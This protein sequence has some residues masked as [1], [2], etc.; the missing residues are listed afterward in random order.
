AAFASKGARLQDDLNGEGGVYP[1]LIAGGCGLVAA[2]D[3]MGADTTTCDS[4]RTQREGLKSDGNRANGVAFGMI[5]VGAVG[6]GLLIGG[7]VAFVQG[8]RA[9][10]TWESSQRARIRVVPTFTGLS[11]QGRF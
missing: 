1:Q 9:S 11:I 4:L 8:K 7:A 3:A 10:A 2:E 5:A 6:V